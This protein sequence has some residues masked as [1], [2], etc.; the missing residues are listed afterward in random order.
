[1]YDKKIIIIKKHL[2][3]YFCFCDRLHPFSEFVTR[4]LKCERS[5]KN[6][7]FVQIQQD[8]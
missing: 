7:V 2:Q 1:M 6:T 5:N 8:E 3:T 4:N